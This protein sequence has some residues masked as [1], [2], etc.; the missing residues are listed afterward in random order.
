MS[1]LSDVRHVLIFELLLTAVVLAFSC[2][3]CSKLILI[4]ERKKIIKGMKGHVGKVAHDQYGSMV[5]T[6][7]GCL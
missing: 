4:Q 3:N 5:R 7:Y 6:T 2:P 1:E